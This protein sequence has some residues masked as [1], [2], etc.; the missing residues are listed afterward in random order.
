MSDDQFY[1][2]ACLNRDVRIERSAKRELILLHPTGLEPGAQNASITAQL[3][4]WTDQDG[5][6]IGFDSSTGF[7][8]PNRAIRSP[9][10]SWVKRSR[11]DNGTCN[12]ARVPFFAEL[13][14]QVSQ[15]PFR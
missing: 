5:S 15:F 6:G 9:D 2:F 8:L 14:E 13:V 11:F 3:G 12:L 10:A 1:E 7:L 4:I